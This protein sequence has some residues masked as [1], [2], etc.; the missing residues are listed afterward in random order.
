MANSMFLFR[1]MFCLET[2]RTISKTAGP[3]YSFW[4]LNVARKFLWVRPP[5]YALDYLIVVSATM[6]RK[7]TGSCLLI[8]SLMARSEVL[9]LAAT[10]IEKELSCQLE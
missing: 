3:P 8:L 5:N 9:I 2:I 4:P 7:A 1:T 6:I 10:A